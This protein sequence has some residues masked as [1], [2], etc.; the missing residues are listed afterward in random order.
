MASQADEI[1]EYALAQYVWPWRRSGGKRL[2][3]RAGDVVRGMRLHNA[4]PNVCSALEGRKFQQQ[5]GLVLVLRAGPRRSTTTTFHYEGG[6]ASSDRSVPADTGTTVRTR[7]PKPRP[8]HPRHERDNGWRAADLCL[9][10]CVSVKRSSPAPARDLYT[11]TWFRKARA[12]VEASRRPWYILSAK[13]G[14]VDPDAMIEP[15]NKTLK[16]MRTSGRRE[17]AHGVLRALEPR[18]PGMSS[19]SF[20]AGAAY[21]EFLEPELH[22]RGI[23]LHVPMEGMGIGRQLSWLDRQLHP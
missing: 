17:W 6:K 21:R 10:S 7:G 11:S 23:A 22:R 4:T 9:V 19:I 16:T 2:S 8:A 3:I 12:L 20:F 14:L 13:Y 1:R 15:Y 5:A 18:L